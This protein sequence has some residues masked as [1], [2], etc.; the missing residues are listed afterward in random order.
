MFCARRGS[1]FKVGRRGRGP[2]TLPSLEDPTTDSHPPGLLVAVRF[3]PGHG[4]F[5]L[6]VLDIPY[7]FATAFGQL[8][9]TRQPL[10]RH[11]CPN[12]GQ[13]RIDATGASRVEDADPTLATVDDP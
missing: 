10:P 13:V 4:G 5:L 1:S 7:R 8:K 9:A 3:F 6:V 2:R 12:A 11:E